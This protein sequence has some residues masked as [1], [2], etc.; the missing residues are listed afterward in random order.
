MA[1]QPNDQARSEGPSVRELLAADTRTVP[2]ALLDAGEPDTGVA[3]VPRSRYTSTEFAD[4]GSALS[5]D[6]D[7]ADGV[8]G[9]SISPTQAT[10]SC[11]T[12]P[13]NRSSSPAPPPAE[14]AAFHNSCLHRGTKLRAQGRTGRLVPLPVPRLA[15]GP[16]RRAGRAAVRLGLP[17]ARRRHSRE[18]PA[19]GRGGP[20]AR[21]RV[22]QPRPRLRAVRVLRL[23]AHRPLRQLVRAGQ[24]LPS[25]SRGEGGAVQLEGLYGGVQR[26]IPRHRDT[27]TDPGVLRRRQQRV[28]ELARRSSGLEVREL[29]RIAEPTPRADDRTGGGR[30]IRHVLRRRRTGH[31][32]YHRH[33]HPPPPPPPKPGPGRRRPSCCAPASR[34]D[35]RPTCPPRATARSS[36]PSCTT[37]SPPSPRGQAW[38]SP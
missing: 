25:V 33:G 31:D 35:S 4:L 26:G 32:R 15:V 27:P 9:G 10:M 29:V 16:R 22:H 37:C 34:S 24:P 19:A 28:R 20:L 1:D 8:Y 11:T 14:I 17:P 5:L 21:L 30:R 12:W 13:I 6:H 18:Q 36:T 38:G 7:L 23:H 2:P 3:E